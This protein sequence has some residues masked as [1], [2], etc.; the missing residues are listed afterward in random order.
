[1]ILIY[2]KNN[3][4]I[5]ELKKDTNEALE[6]YN[7]LL[8]RYGDDISFVSVVGVPEVSI[9]DGVEE[10]PY[11]MIIHVEELSH[12]EMIEETQYTD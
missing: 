6:T 4:N 5:I 8:S 7:S 10:D 12:G 3:E 1:M 9:M 11:Q 2:T